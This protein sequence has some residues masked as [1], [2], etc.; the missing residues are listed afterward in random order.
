MRPDR[1]ALFGY[2]HVPWMKTHQRMID[3][4]ALPDV[5][6]R[7]HQSRFASNKLIAAGYEP[8][9]LDHFALPRDSLAVAARSGHLR[10]NFQGY[11]T[12]SA[13][14]LIGLGAS[15]VGSLPQ[16]YVQ[17]SIPTGDYIRR[18]RDGKLATVRGF[19]FTV[20]DRMRGY[21]IEQLMCNAQ[22]DVRQLESLFGE[23]SSHVVDDMRLLCALDGEGLVTF[24]G[25]RLAMTER[26]RPFVRAIAS[27]FDTYL[28]AG[29][30]R[31]SVA[32]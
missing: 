1:I 10:R 17:N 29:Q 5:V 14:A 20:E 21:V 7:Y 3:E 16:G 23:Q 6:E 9:G 12:D 25:R 28:D 30:K 24:D 22:V 32:V 11:T 19:E 26:G 27:V 18:V 4:T 2:A 8:I 13:P 15:S 31:H